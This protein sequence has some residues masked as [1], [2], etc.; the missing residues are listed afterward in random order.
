[1]HEVFRLLLFVNKNMEYDVAARILKLAMDGAGKL[2]ET[3]QLARDS[4]SPSEFATWQAAIGK[5]MGA[6]YI[7]LIDRVF[8]E[9]P[10]LIP[11]EFDNEWERSLS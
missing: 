1:M 9:H 4:C 3:A 7:E 8:R 10:S 2:N 11:A 5:A 6:I